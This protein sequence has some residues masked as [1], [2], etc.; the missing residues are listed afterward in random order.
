MTFPI[1]IEH[2]D[3]S[4]HQQYRREL[5][6]TTTI[7]AVLAAA[8]LLP[9]A[10]GMPF[11][12][13]AMGKPAIVASYFACLIL[14]FAT[15]LRIVAETLYFALFVHRQHREIW[16]GNLLFL[17][18]AFGLNILLIPRLGL[19]GL[20]IAALIAAAGLLAWRA[21]YTIKHKP[22]PAG[23]QAPWPGIEEIID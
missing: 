21:F 5:R 4:D 9:L 3:R 12:A 22:N 20:S 23:D 19:T 6:K 8:I 13:R 2:Y 1:L 17:L 15:W 10:V 11:L 16:L 7:A 14:L 18:V